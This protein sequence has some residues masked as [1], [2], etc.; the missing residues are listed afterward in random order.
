MIYVHCMYKR[1]KSKSVYGR[2]EMAS[3][4]PNAVCMFYVLL[5]YQ[6]PSKSRK[7]SG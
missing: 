6:F 2:E 3:E 7:T 5:N 1:W 4:P